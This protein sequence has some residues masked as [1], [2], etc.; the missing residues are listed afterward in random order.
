MG[1]M[2][3]GEKK[4]WVVCSEKEGGGKGKPERECRVAD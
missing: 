1:E 2:E 4:M 3:R